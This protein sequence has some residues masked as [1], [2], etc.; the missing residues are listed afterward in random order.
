MKKNVH[1][2]YWDV[3]AGR[4]T[5]RSVEAA[6]INALVDATK[7]GIYKVYRDLQERESADTQLY[8]CRQ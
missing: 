8:F 2:K 7:S 6:E 1:P 5:G 4:A 3:K